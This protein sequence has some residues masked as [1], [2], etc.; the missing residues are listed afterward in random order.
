MPGQYQDESEL[1]H[2]EEVLGIV[3]VA[4]P[5]ATKV[6][7]PSKQPLDSPTP[8]VSMQGASVLSLAPVPAIGGDH[9]NASLPHL[10]VQTVAVV[11][12]VPNQSLRLALSEATIKSRLDKSYF[13]R[14]STFDMYGDRKTSAVCDCHDLGPLAPLGFPET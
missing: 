12:L 9:L 8:T 7:E 10:L 2:T 5:K 6:E 13:V 3:L 14:G 11:R 1:N 4:N